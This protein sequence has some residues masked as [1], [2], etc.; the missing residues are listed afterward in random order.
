MIISEDELPP[1]N[2]WPYVWNILILHFHFCIVGSYFC[3]KIFICWGYRTLLIVLMKNVPVFK[4]HLFLINMVSNCLETWFRKYAWFLINRRHLTFTLF[5]Y[6]SC[7]LFLCFEVYPSNG[8]S[9]VI[10]WLRIHLSMQRMRVW[11]LIRGVKISY[12]SGSKNQY[13]KPKQY[14]NK[15]NKDLKNVPHQK[16]WKK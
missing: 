5:S 16:I 1:H 7:M 2:S 6:Y 14:C 3:C 11:V 15:F 4:W 8:T 12:A 9:L 13:T 10:Q